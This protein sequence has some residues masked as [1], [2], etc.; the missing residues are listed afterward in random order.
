MHKDLADKR[1]RKRKQP[2]SV[3][4]PVKAAEE[5]AVAAA[6]AAVGPA[7]AAPDDD[8]EGDAT[9]GSLP[10]PAAGGVSAEF[11]CAPGPGAN[12]EQQQQH[13]SPALREFVRYAGIVRQHCAADSSLV[14]DVDTMCRLV[15]RAL[16]T[17]SCSTHTPPP[18]SQAA[19]A[20]AAQAVQQQQVEEYVRLESAVKTCCAGSSDAV[21]AVSRMC[22]IA[23]KA[24]K[25]Q[26]NRGGRLLL[27]L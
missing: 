14:A 20:A 1:G 26:D 15:E 23:F 3:L 17:T 7:A 16:T 12:Q 22:E 24:I 13:L 4:Q 8:D 2:E 9:Q 11:A 19:A 21:E 6:A 27:L 18:P 10:S 25:Q 5:E